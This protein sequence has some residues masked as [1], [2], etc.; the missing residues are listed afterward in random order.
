[1]VIVEATQPHGILQQNGYQKFVP[2]F[3]LLPGVYVLELHLAS[4]TN[5]RTYRFQVGYG[6][7]HSTVVKSS[8]L[9]CRGRFPH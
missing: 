2:I 3:V 7:A 6:N 8:Y 1:M 9:I 5:I 4:T